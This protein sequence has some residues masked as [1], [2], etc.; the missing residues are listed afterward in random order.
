M[1]TAV[2]LCS[3][4]AAGGESLP[5]CDT[6]GCCYLWLVV[7]GKVVPVCC[8]YIFPSSLCWEKNAEIRKRVTD[9][10]AGAAE[11]TEQ[12]PGQPCCSGSW[13]GVHLP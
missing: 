12:V 7:N 13:P 10:G 6:E 4:Q 8:F 1:C 3:T 9:S 2:P 11:S 5:L